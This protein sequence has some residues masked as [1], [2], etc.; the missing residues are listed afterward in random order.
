MKIKHPVYVIL[1]RIGPTMPVMLKVG[2][3]NDTRDKNHHD[4]DTNYDEGFV[5]NDISLHDMM[6]RMMMMRRRMMMNDDD[7]DDK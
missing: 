7:G 4:N 6:T 5:G 1:G 2:V 3:D